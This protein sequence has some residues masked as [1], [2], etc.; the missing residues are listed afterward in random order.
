MFIIGTSSA[1]ISNHPPDQDTLFRLQCA[2]WIWRKKLRNYKIIAY[3][4]IGLPIVYIATLA[5]WMELAFCLLIYFGTAMFADFHI[6]TVLSRL[7]RVSL[8]IDNEEF[9][10]PYDE[11]LIK[12]VPGQSI[13]LVSDAA[14]RYMYNVKRLKRHITQLDIDIIH[15]LNESP[16]NHGQPI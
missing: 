8:Q 7:H 4:G 2:S 6:Q 10:R 5:T 16:K 12:P 1:G 9:A 13:S 3:I 14:N 15:Y 11:D